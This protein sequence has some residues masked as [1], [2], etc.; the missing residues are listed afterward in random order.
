MERP[1]VTQRAVKPNFAVIGLS[2]LGLFTAARLLQA[3]Y[4]VI[5]FDQSGFQRARVQQGYAL[6]DDKKT[7]AL[8]RRLAR[9]GAFIL[10]ESI[11]K[12]LEGTNV[13]IICE[14]ARINDRKILQVRTLHELADSIGKSMQKG[15][16]IVLQTLAPPG[17]ARIFVKRCEEASG[18]TCGK[19]FDFVYAPS[20]L[21]A[22]D[23]FD[24][25]LA[26]V[27][28]GSSPKA[29]S[30]V[31]EA[32]ENASL[33]KCF[34]ASSFEAAEIGVMRLHAEYCLKRALR[35]ELSSL[36]DE[37][38]ASFDEAEAIFMNMRG[39]GLK[40]MPA[41][42][43]RNSAAIVTNL[44]EAGKSKG[45]S[46]P[47]CRLARDVCWST[48][49]RLSKVLIKWLKSL[50]PRDRSLTVISIFREFDF[51]DRSSHP[52]LEVVD[53]L[54]RAKIKVKLSREGEKEGRRSELGILLQPVEKALKESRNVAVLSPGV[55]EVRK[56]DRLDGLR[57][58]DFNDMAGV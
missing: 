30:T 47:L 31:S 18:L 44:L 51:V 46:L 3:G 27:V 50:E 55:G 24:H 33:G 17:T 5:G 12:A 21:T 22:S 34:H 4:A 13:A 39:G 2:R 1:E 29:V 6:E 41:L 16:T 23:D 45:V 54:Y 43:A 9:E 11:R 7:S 10:V 52:E 26:R 40:T 49:Q 42:F 38:G 37:M 35:A 57:V 20:P 58:L 28:V 15:V 25:D 36:C 14:R 53:A 32:F 48:P 19:D 56:N 8:L